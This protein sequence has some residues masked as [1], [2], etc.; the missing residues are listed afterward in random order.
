MDHELA[1]LRLLVVGASSGIGRAI[2]LAA[3]AGGARVAFAARRRQLL[4]ETA[5]QAGR[6]CTAVEVDVSD[7]AT[8]D[9][10]VST[11]VTRLGGLDAVVYAT[12]SS[13]LVKL[14]DADGEIWRTVLQ[15]NAA[16]A[17]LV[18]R[19]ALPHLRRAPRGRVAVLSSHSVEDPWPGLVPYVVSKAALDALV[20]GWRAEV[21]DVPITR[22]VV[23]PTMTEFAQR[24]DDG[25]AAE[26][27]DRWARE[28]RLPEHPTVM[29][30]A[31]V[32]TEV[33][34]ALGS[35]V[36][37]SDLRLVPRASR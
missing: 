9:G 31:Q 35:P 32:A 34:H 30:P 17:G 19:A 18:L 10:A 2:G 20:H 24:W 36:L 21:P 23:G 29:E 26:L 14:Q 5:E 25:L 15:T 22:V 1:G 4:E 27:F 8:V 6:E 28:G 37:V 7:E 33:L 13:P 16:G 12:G 11:T 3:A